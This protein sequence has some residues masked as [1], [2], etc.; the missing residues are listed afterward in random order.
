MTYKMKINNVSSQEILDALGGEF[1]NDPD[2]MI[3]GE[4]AIISLDKMNEEDRQILIDDLMA[5]GHKF[6]Y[7]SPR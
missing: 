4:R 1:L 2:T 6:A 3:S 5:D 7:Y